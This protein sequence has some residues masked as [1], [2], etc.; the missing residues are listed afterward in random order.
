MW[1]D[2]KEMSTFVISLI[3]EPLKCYTI[4]VIVTTAS[5]Y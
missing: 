3:L 1:I 4:D 2:S 5:E